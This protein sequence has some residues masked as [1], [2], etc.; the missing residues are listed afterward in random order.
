MDK[1]RTI[2]CYIDTVNNNKD[3]FN[4]Y[5]F[6]SIIDLNLVKLDLILKHG[7]LSKRLIEQQNLISLYTHDSCDF[8]SKNGSSYV[9]LTEYL[10]STF[11][12]LFESFPLH[13][14][15]SVSLLVNKNI[16]VYHHGERES[17]FDDEVFVLDMIPKDKIE[18][19]MLPEHLSQLPISKISCLPNDLSCYTKRYISYWLSCM[20]LYFDTQINEKDIYN[21]MC[22]YNQLWSILNEYE[23]PEK[24]FHLAIKE[25][26]NKYGFD[27]NDLLST[28]LEKF[29]S[30]KLAISEPTYIDVLSN[31]NNNQLPVFEIKQKK[32]KRIN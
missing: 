20:Q 24:F 32:L 2:E 10:N 25:Q 29:W 13:T 4:N 7:I 14:L 6:H 1:I 28:L 15:T 8:D 3:F 22:S 16:D 11:N 27:L 26:R 31:I 9:S 12:P 23:A 21:I 5:Y 17:Y 30:E 18:G 19:I